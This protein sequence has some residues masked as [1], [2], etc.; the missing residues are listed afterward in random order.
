M[1]GTS[2]VLNFV[3]CLFIRI[4]TFLILII[5][6]SDSYNYSLFLISLSNE[7]TRLTYCRGNTLNG[8]ATHSLWQAH[9]DLE[10][11]SLKSSWGRVRPL[12]PMIGGAT[13]G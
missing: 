1:N 6:I 13:P 4:F 10:E 5:F 8:R 12:Y 3:F 7:N 9:V 2:V 11:V